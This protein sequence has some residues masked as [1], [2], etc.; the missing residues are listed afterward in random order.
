MCFQ[1]SNIFC[2]RRRRSYEYPTVGSSNVTD[3]GSGYCPYMEKPI[4]IQESEYQ[5]THTRQPPKC[6]HKRP[7]VKGFRPIPEGETVEDVYEENRETPPVTMANDTS[8][9]TGITRPSFY[10]K[11]LIDKNIKMSHGISPQR[12]KTN[13]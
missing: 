5:C 9:S 6:P 7:D 4:Q 10:E 13:L 8:L 12:P 1:N 11:P 2:R 3:Q